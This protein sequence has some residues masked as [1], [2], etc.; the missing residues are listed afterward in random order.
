MNF[1]KLYLTLNESHYDI[2]SSQLAISY[3]PRFCLRQLHPHSFIR[4]TSNRKGGIPITLKE[5]YETPSFLLP[6]AIPLL[7]PPPHYLQRHPPPRRIN[8]NAHETPRDNARD[9][10]REQPSEVDPSDHAP[11]NRLQIARADADRNRRAGNTLRGRDRQ[12]ETRSK[13]DG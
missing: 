4:E 13:D 12:R 3:V 8:N 6:R 1:Q 11:I 7:A 10:Q 9:W 2:C 5:T